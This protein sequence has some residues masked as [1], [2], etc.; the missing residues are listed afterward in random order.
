MS[1]KIRYKRRLRN[2]KKVLIT[3]LLLGAITLEEITMSANAQDNSV[4]TGQVLQQ[5]RANKPTK[6]KG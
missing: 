5:E 3:G 6:G 4:V 2:I 1:I